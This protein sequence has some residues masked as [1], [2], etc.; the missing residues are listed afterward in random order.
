MGRDLVL[1]RQAEQNDWKVL[2]DNWRKVGSWA[3]GRYC[4]KVMYI[5]IIPYFAVIAA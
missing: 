4:L 2:T 1:L 3:S 5:H